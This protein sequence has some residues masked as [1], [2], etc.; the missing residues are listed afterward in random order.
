M[1]NFKFIFEYDFKNK[2][3]VV[4]SRYFTSD[5]CRLWKAFVFKCHMVAHSA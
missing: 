1:N 4:K 5:R 3:A 2:V